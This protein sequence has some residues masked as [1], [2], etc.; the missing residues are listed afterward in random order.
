MI[1]L[2]EAK[3]WKMCLTLCFVSVDELNFVLGLNSTFSSSLTRYNLFEIYF[4]LDCV[5][6]QQV[7]SML[8][9]TTPITS[10]NFPIL[11]FLFNHHINSSTFLLGHFGLILVIIGPALGQQF[12]G[13][14][15]RCLDSASLFSFQL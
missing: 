14:L 1:C 10:R 13:S 3:Y 5:R 8:P 9:G 2:S 7:L 6:C 11:L 4:L 12:T 15:D